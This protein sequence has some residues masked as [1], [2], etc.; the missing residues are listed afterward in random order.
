MQPRRCCGSGVG[1]KGGF[2]K[3]QRHIV[4]G[5]RCESSLRA[6]QGMSQ[7]LTFESRRQW[8]RPTVQGQSLGK[9]SDRSPSAEVGVRRKQY[10]HA[11]QR[12]RDESKVSV[13]LQKQ[14]KNQKLLL[15]SSNIHKIPPKKDPLP[16]K[17]KQKLFYVL[18]TRLRVSS[19]HFPPPIQ[20][21]KTLF[22]RSF[23]FPFASA[24]PGG[25]SFTSFGPKR[26]RKRLICD[27]RSRQLDR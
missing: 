18:K 27:N 10:A 14:G 16:S 15:D 21:A 20:D 11:A 25:G 8:P 5:L 2:F 6:W 22:A 9:G 23:S 26:S 7:R 4:R 13:R 19:I 3:N 12:T 1:V 24:S 17:P